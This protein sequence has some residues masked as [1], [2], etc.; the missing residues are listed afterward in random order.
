MTALGRRKGQ[1]WRTPKEDPKTALPTGSGVGLRS[2]VTSSLW[3]SEYGR[4][5]SW[6][7]VLVGFDGE[8]ATVGP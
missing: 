7:E 6:E 4:L 1:G 8:W 2:G 5:R 3:V